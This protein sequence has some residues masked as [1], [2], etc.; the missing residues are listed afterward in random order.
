MSAEVI[1]CAMYCRTR[2][3][4]PIARCQGSNVSHLSVIDGSEEHVVM[5]LQCIRIHV[6]I[7]R[8]KSSPHGG[9]HSKDLSIID[10]LCTELLSHAEQVVVCCTVA[11]P[12]H[13]DVDTGFVSHNS[14]M[15][16]VLCRP[17]CRLRCIVGSTFDLVFWAEAIAIPTCLL[18][19][20][21]ILPS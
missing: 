13:H 9:K 11:I 16:L 10:Q 7:C 1:Y 2:S 18:L 14:Q 17:D 8:V 4:R 3:V 5:R 6:S 21:N 20:I 19:V 15:C 12:D